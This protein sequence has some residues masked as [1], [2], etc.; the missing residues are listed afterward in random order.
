MLFRYWC[1]NLGIL[2]YAT[3]RDS[4]L[5]LRPP[6]GREMD[7]WKGAFTFIRVD[8]TAVI[9]Q[10]YLFLKQ[11]FN[12]L[13]HYIIIDAAPLY[14][15]GWGKDGCCSRSVQLTLQ[16][17]RWKWDRPQA[18]KTTV[19]EDSGTGHSRTQTVER[20]TERLLS[21]C[22]DA[23][24]YTSTRWRTLSFTIM[25]WSCV[26]C[27]HSLWSWRVAVH[28]SRLDTHG[29]TVQ[30]IRQDWFGRPGST[31]AWGGSVWGHSAGDVSTRFA[32]DVVGT[33]SL[34][35]RRQL[36]LL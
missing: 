24:L 27:R 11:P 2:F 26:L 19:T 12:W 9:I 3:P 32:V 17:I 7:G 30:L 6:E 20:N 8:K 28:C 34:Y 10:F 4:E 18:M 5:G 15:S 31:V 35:Y 1:W 36:L 25:T 14:H 16:I 29:H 21:S 22:C 23:T 13:F 33:V